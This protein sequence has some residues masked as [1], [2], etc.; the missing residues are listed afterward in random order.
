MFWTWIAQAVLESIFLSVVPLYLLA[1]SGSRGE[2]GSF[3]EAGATTF[4]A[5]ICTINI[6][7][8]R[9]QRER[10]R[11]KIVGTAV[12]AMFLIFVGGYWM[13]VL[14]MQ[15]RWYWFSVLIVVSSILSWWGIA[16]IVSNFVTLDYDWFWVSHKQ[17][18][19]PYYLFRSFHIL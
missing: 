8:G 5:I 11:K 9:A 3:W 15:C 6:K 18:F 17:L 16:A 1:N 19:L 4:T 12:W 14:F 10:E 13:Q 7:V 2:S